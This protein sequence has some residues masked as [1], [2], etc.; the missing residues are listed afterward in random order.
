VTNPQPLRFGIAGIGAGASNLLEGFIR[1]PRVRITAAA[2][3]RADALQAFGRQ[4]GAKTFQSVEDLCRSPQVDVVWVATPNRL[5]AQHAILAADSGKHV[6]VS[7]P[8]AM[9]LQQ[10]EAMIEAADRNGVELLVGHSQGLAPTVRKMAELVHSGEYGKLGMVHTW[11]YTDWVYRPRLPAE[12]DEGQGG[13]V[14]FRQAPH[15]IDIVR[16]IGGQP[17]RSVRAASLQLDPGRA[18]TGAYVAYLEFEDGTP[19]TLVYSGYGHFKSPELTAGRART[20]AQ[21]SKGTTA[22][23]ERALKE[24]ARYGGGASTAS[25]EATSASERTHAIFGLT[26]V[27]CQ[28]ADIRQAPRGVLVYGDSGKQ[29]IVVPPDE[30]GEAEFEEMYRAVRHGRPILH[31]G[32]WGLATHEATLAILESARQRKEI[33]LTQQG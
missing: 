25:E 16:L 2:D 19:A 28:L 30:R 11:H 26:L 21:V 5:H 20:W 32:R 9:T 12:L 18:T 17:L 7:K 13:G 6:I 1:S 15:Q 4:F 23:E 22:E 33:A 29:E 8:M 31:D 10:C 3:V 24:A 27:S 14:V